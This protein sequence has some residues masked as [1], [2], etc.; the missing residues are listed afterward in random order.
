M[1]EKNFIFVLCPP[2]QGSTVIYRLLN[3]S[4]N[5]TTFL[6]KV[7]WMGEGHVLIR[8]NIHNNW[9]NNRWDPYF[10]IN[11]S[12]VSDVY[13]ENWD[14]TK[15]VFVEKSPTTICRA[16]KFEEE[17]SKLGNVHFIVQIR[18]PFTCRMPYRHPHIPKCI[19]QDKRNMITQCKVW[20]EYAR[21]QKNNLEN[22]N[23]TYFLTYEKLCT[24]T[25]S[26]ID[27]LIEKFPFLGSLNKTK[28]NKGE[29]KKKFSQ[30][31]SGERGG[32]IS[33]KS[34][35]RGNLEVKSDFFKRKSELLDYFNL[36]KP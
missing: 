26:V 2:F 17:F 8:K 11:M 5:A 25:D 21:I 31:Y 15:K 1:S 24:E 30:H 7:A 13:M 34:S 16:E 14:Q 29:Y 27:E 10:D 23:N 35:I 12:K 6:D 32:N 33:F 36:E 3:T 22:L 19:I 9:R 4:P 18:N 20:N 28:I